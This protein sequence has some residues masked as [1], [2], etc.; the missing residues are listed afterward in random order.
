MKPYAIV[1]VGLRLG[2]R[3]AKDDFWDLLQSQRDVTENAP[4][5][6]FNTE[7]IIGDRDEPGH[8]AL[9]MR[10]GFLKNA[11][12]FDPLAFGIGFK[13]AAML[14]LS[15]RLALELALDALDDA[16]VPFR[17]TSTG[18]FSTGC[19]GDEVILDGDL[20]NEYYVTGSTMS[21]IANRVSFALDLKGPSVTI[22][23]ACSSSLVVLDAAISSIETGHCKQAVAIGVNVNAN[24]KHWVG[25]SQLGVLSKKGHSRPFDAAA[26]GYI[27]SEG[28]A[29]VVVKP[30]ADALAAGDHIYAVVTGSAVNSSGRGPSLTYPSAPQQ[31]ALMREALA[32]SGRAV[33]EVVYAELHGTGTPVGD[34]IE[35]NAMGT[36]FATARSS[37]RPPVWIGSVKGTLGHLEVAAGMASLV[38]V[39]LMMERRMAVPQAN[40]SVPNPNI[41]WDE[42]PI[43]V[44]R[45]AFPLSSLAEDGKLVCT[46]NSFGF[47]G[48]N[49]AVVVESCDVA[50]AKTTPSPKS[51]DAVFP[52]LFVVGALTSAGATEMARV[53][54]SH[55][56]AAADTDALA[57]N[58]GRRAAMYTWRT[59]S[60]GDKLSPLL[61]FPEPIQTS[62]LSACAAAATPRPAHQLAFVFSGQGPQHQDLGRGLFERFPAFRA[63]ILASDALIKARTGESLLEKYNLF[64]TADVAA[65]PARAGGTPA[66]WPIDK[67]VLSIAVLQMA[68]FD[69]WVEVLGRRPDVVLGH[70]V[71]EIGMLYAS[72]ACSRETAI[73][74]AVGRA[75]AMASVDNTGGAMVALG[76][77]EDR[78]DE[79][80]REVL[81]EE[82]WGEKTVQEG[83]K[84]LSEAEMTVLTPPAS[85]P[86][87]QVRGL[88]MAAANA[89]D[90]VTVSGN[91]DL[92]EKLEARAKAEGVFARVLRVNSAFHSPL[93]EP[94]RGL[95]GSAMA[96]AFALQGPQAMPTTPVA[97]AVTGE[98]WPEETPFAADYML[99][100]LRQPVLFEKALKSMLSRAEN[101]T[102]V[103]IAA[104]PVLATSMNGVA[105]ASEVIGSM[106]RMKTGTSIIDQMRGEVKTL[107]EG[108]GTL[109][110]KGYPLDFTILAGSPETV[111]RI[112]LPLYPLSKR[113]ITYPNDRQLLA[114]A[115]GPAYSNRLARR[116]LH[117][118]PRLT[119]WVTHHRV[120]GTPVVPATA[121]ASIIFQRG[122]AVV[123]DVSLHRGCM[124]PDGVHCDI[125]MDPALG[126]WW[127]RS[128]SQLQADPTLDDKDARFDVLHASGAFGARVPGDLAD[129]AA[130]TVDVGAA[131]SRCTTP[132]SYTRLHG[133]L[134]RAAFDLGETFGA[135]DG[136]MLSEDGREVVW[137]VCVPAEVRA[138]PGFA[139]FAV[140][141]AVLDMIATLPMLVLL[142][143]GATKGRPE[144]VLQPLSIERLVRLDG[145][146]TGEPFDFVGQP[147]VALGSRAPAKDGDKYAFS[148]SIAHA[149]TGRVLFLIDN[150]VFKRV[151]QE[152]EESAVDEE[153]V[154]LKD[155]TTFR[156]ETFEFPCAVNAPLPETVST[157]GTALLVSQIEALL[158]NAKENGRRLV[159]V[160]EIA[161]G[162]GAVTT[163]LDTVLVDMD[164]KEKLL[165]ELVVSDLK[166]D[167]KRLMDTL[168]HRDV[169]VVSLDVTEPDYAR[170]LAADLSSGDRCILPESFDIVVSRNLTLS[171]K[172]LE[173]ILDL[174]VPG[175]YLVACSAATEPRQDLAA[176]LAEAKFAHAELATVEAGLL[177]RARRSAVDQDWPQHVVSLPPMPAAVGEIVHLHRGGNE[178]ELVAKVKAL[179]HNVT[180]RVD[181]WIVADESAEG[182]KAV[183]IVSSI[184]DEERLHWKTRLSRLECQGRRQIEYFVDASRTLHVRKLLGASRTTEPFASESW[185]LKVSE[186][187]AV[188]PLDTFT[189]Q[190]AHTPYALG[191]HDVKVQVD[192]VA[193]NYRDMLTKTGVLKGE[194]SQ[195]MAEFSGVVIDV[196]SQVT[197][198][199][200]GQVVAGVAEELTNLVVIDEGE[201]SPA[202]AD[203]SLEQSAGFYFAFLTA[204][205]SLVTVARIRKGERLLIQ[206]ATSPPG[207]AAIQIAQR[208]GARV[209]CTART[210]ED[211]NF[212]LEVIGMPSEA[213]SDSRDV[214]IWTRDLRRWANEE[215]GAGCVDVVMNTVTDTGLLAGLNALR[216]FG[217]FL[218]L[219]KRDIFSGTEVSLRKLARQ[220]SIH[221]I[222]MNLV[223]THQ[224]YVFREA[225]DDLLAAHHSSP[226]SVHV[227]TSYPWWEVKTAYS[228]LQEGSHQGTI[229]L[230]KF[231]HKL[232]Q[233]VAEMLG[234]TADELKETAALSSLGLDSISA[235]R[236]KVLLAQRYKVNVTQMELLG[237][238]TLEKLKSKMK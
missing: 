162:D 59:F 170:R 190:S 52:N 157:D 2:N 180:E 150:L 235:T 33:D 209:F 47:G 76:C 126:R 230:N 39:L 53:T 213:V 152:N 225:V 151:E 91:R 108:C 136:A 169:R 186:P 16:R 188:N 17:G 101:T 104:H 74:I 79:L 212:L 38:K 135:L 3:R 182:A 83:G 44:V 165:V 124:V 89:V 145:K 158:R 160:L 130:L 1:G 54:S 51:N 14:S 228:R 210:P 40:F 175:G 133:R 215:S 88:W 195:S 26:D 71:G 176:V 102:I 172:S 141:P 167:E 163:A 22:E 123:K 100:N 147:L 184:P 164:K 168:K 117:M 203:L 92:V 173:G 78:A 131:R 211:W 60:V 223:K 30:L 62:S 41:R 231:G 222:D 4:A 81:A 143:D 171:P 114:Q 82:K 13:E 181:V 6:R 58:L 18:V 237:S 25:F 67:V 113:P 72:G 68:L 185:A 198:F 87:Q 31:T 139:R 121:F 159:R 191:Q 84:E 64:A 49:S 15:Q 85:P 134:D 187:N 236:L 35:T 50:R 127:F 110:V 153:E 107:L 21:L 178:M 37:D 122:A 200:L 137:D 238:M 199:Q 226:F 142:D 202:P 105:G 5:E 86:L 93:M 66:S 189:R 192:S 77:G 129:A 10:G 221:V 144:A 196:G 201:L 70:S 116:R 7:L 95:M 118:H 234:M 29:A 125:E 12:D 61:K 193:L 156:W 194:A 161:C 197:R 57:I 73:A 183:G 24:V 103:E 179:H 216:P 45:E 98:M 11:Y 205:Y 115:V 99:R 217:R 140:H 220:C 208:I 75:A 94:C 46:I 206:Q 229:V 227:D 128:S 69:L 42:L 109:F 224:P 28:G 155:G 43:K 48:T 111:P 36:V 56:H 34:P 132:L 96:A 148:F 27:R 232:K 23:T 149:E 106:V 19:C 80:I 204:W 65:A 166:P 138:Q 9:N 97:S 219:G 90:A 218:E 207:L 214:D 233:E 174:F 177:V 146:V 55:P 154:A 20:S 119:P 8:V 63:S 120:G 112:E 32:V